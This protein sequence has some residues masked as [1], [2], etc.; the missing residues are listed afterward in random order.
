[1]KASK[2]EVVKTPPKS[3]ITA[4][5]ATYA[6]SQVRLAQQEAGI[7]TRPRQR[8]NGVVAGEFGF[9]PKLPLALRA[10]YRARGSSI[11]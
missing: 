7:E 6:S 1:L 11:H 10:K 5:I 2:G 3:Q 4:S 9:A 8:K